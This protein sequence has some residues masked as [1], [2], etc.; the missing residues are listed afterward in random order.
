[1]S[2]WLIF[3][4]VLDINHD[5]VTNDVKHVDDTNL[6][7]LTC[8]SPA[9]NAI[10]VPS[11]GYYRHVQTTTTLWIVAAIDADTSDHGLNFLHWVERWQWIWS[12]SSNLLYARG[13]PS[14]GQSIP[15][16]VLRLQLNPELTCHRSLSDEHLHAYKDRFINNGFNNITTV[17][18]INWLMFT[19]ITT[20]VDN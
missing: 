17:V 12:C 16:L 4:Q 2:F 11:T 14:P 19:S 18:N 15:R 6:M 1:M 8:T 20:N 9:T 3:G 7:G 5:C 13:S 10:L